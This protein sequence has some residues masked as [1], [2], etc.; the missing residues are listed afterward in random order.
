MPGRSSIVPGLVA[1][2]LDA[3]AAFGAGMGSLYLTSASQ[4]VAT[5]VVVGA[6]AL[7]AAV[8]L[9]ERGSYT[10]G[11]LFA[12][13]LHLTRLTAAWLQ[14]VGLGVLLTLCTLTALRHGGTISDGD[15][16]AELFDGPWLPL[17]VGTGLVALALVRVGR[18]RVFL[19]QVPPRRAVVVGATALCQQVLERLDRDGHGGLNIVGIVEYGA[20]PRGETLASL[21]A[22]YGRTVLGGMPAL[23]EL[24][25]QD[26]IDSVIVALPWSAEA[27]I[28]DIV[29]QL[30]ASPVDIYVAPSLEGVT[31]SGRQVA[32]IG[33][34]PMLQ[35]GQRPLQGWR[36]MVKRAEDVAAAGA[37]LVMAAPAL[38]VIAAA[39]KVTSPGPVFFRQRRVGFNNQIFEVFKFRTMYTHMTDADAAQQTRKGD[40]RVTRVGAILRKTSLDE[41]PQLLNVLKGDMSLVGPRPHALQT[42][43]CGLPLEDVAP[44]YPARHRVKPGITGWAQ[45]NGYRGELDTTEKVIHR[46]N[47]DLYYIDN[48]SLG[49]DLRIL[50]QTARLMISDRNAY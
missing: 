24:V 37:M 35:A 40:P 31:F 19:S 2:I 22:F 39:V 21:R 27:A 47:H 1:C 20:A 18:R 7:L 25:R 32:P 38:L 15:A 16:L 9:W 11:I 14:A 13:R 42:R 34:V 10:L 30:A 46:V 3:I 5:F 29:Q 49:L 8:G 28:R 17:F 12:R 48:W 41:L 43:A 45:V 36:A 4:G 33:G 50:W 26:A 6:V 44:N 23:L